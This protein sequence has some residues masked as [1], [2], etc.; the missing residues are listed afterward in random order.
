MITDYDDDLI[1]MI[2]S[3]NIVFLLSNKQND[4]DVFCCCCSSCFF[5][6]QFDWL[7]E[8]WIQL[9]IKKEKQKQKRHIKIEKNEW[10][11]YIKIFLRKQ[12]ERISESNSF[13]L[14]K[15]KKIHTCIINLYL[16]GCVQYLE[17]MTFDCFHCFHF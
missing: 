9:K 16:V 13:F 2:T 6:R 15:K 8:S 4:V 10:S 1:K 17:S 11:D 5:S 3:A 14:Y 12:R 7:I